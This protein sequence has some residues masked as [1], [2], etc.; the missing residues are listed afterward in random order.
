MGA[1]W[2]PSRCAVP[3]CDASASATSASRSAQRVAV[4]PPQV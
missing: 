2:R 4:L 1:A 3:G